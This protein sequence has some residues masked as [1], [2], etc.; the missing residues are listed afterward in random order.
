MHEPDGSARAGHAAGRCGV[1]NVGSGG[2]ASGGG[3]TG[4]AGV[5]GIGNSGGTPATGGSPQFGSGGGVILPPPGSGGQGA[6]GMSPGTGGMVVTKGDPVIPPVSGDCPAWTNTTIDFMGLPGVQIAVGAKPEAPTAPMLLYWHGTGS[7]AGEFAALAAPVSQGITAAGG[8]IV[9]PQGTTGGDLNSGTLIFGA[10]DL[11]V[12]DQLVACAVKDRNVDPHKIYTMG[13]SAGGLMATATA[14]LR[15]NY[16]AAAA[17]NSGGVTLAPAF[18]G[19]HTPPLMTVHGAMG[20]DVVIVD[21]FTDERCG[22]YLVQ[23]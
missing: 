15:S 1:G 11:K 18:E 21:F 9:S 4:I 22:R 5:T 17:P 19:M 2:A 8:V 13:C 7:T 3:S 10:S 23:G 16:I 12:M 6:G 20:S 14:I